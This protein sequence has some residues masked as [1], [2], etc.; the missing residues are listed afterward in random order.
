MTYEE[1]LDYLNHYG[2]SQWKLG[3]ERTLGLLEKLGNP[4]KKLKFIHV[5]GSNGKGST[6][7][8]LERIFRE[9]GYKTGFFPSPYI[10]D[11]RERIQVSGDYISKESLARLTERVAD[12]CDT[13]AEHPT[14]FEMITAL[15]FLYF[16]EQNCDLVILEVGLGGSFDS[17]NVIDPPECAVITH[18][19]L[20]HTEY[21]GDTLA[22]IAEA[23]AGIIKTGS[24]VVTYENAREAM[25]VIKQVCAEKSCP[26]Y[27][28]DR[29]RV[30][31]VSTSFDGQKLVA[32]HPRQYFGN[33][34]SCR[35][36]AFLQNEFLLSEGLSLTLSLIG[37]YQLDNVAVVLTVVEV[38]RSRGYSVPEDAVCAGLKKVNWPARF[39]VLSREP[40]LIL[41]GGHNPQCAEALAETIRKYLPDEKVTF[42][43][44]VLADKDVDKILDEVL[45]LA[46]YFICLTPDSPRALAADEL[47]HIIQNKYSSS[48][49]PLSAHPDETSY[50]ITQTDNTAPQK[51]KSENNNCNTKA[52]SSFATAVSSVEEALRTAFKQN[53]PVIAFG[54]LYLAGQIR[55]R[56]KQPC[57]QFERSL[58]LS[59]RK[60]LSPAERA[61]KSK[62][63]CERIK[64]LPILEKAVTVLSYK[65]DGSEVDLTLINQY[66]EEKDIRVAYPVSGADGIM[67]AY[68]PQEGSCFEK[69]AFG[70]L[71]P[72]PSQSTLIHPEEI[73]LILIPCVAFDDEGNRMGHGKGYYDRYL[74]RCNKHVSAVQVA[75]EAQRI[76]RLVL[77]ETDEKPGHIVTE[78]RIL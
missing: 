77:I 25:E 1:A 52:D 69:G 44:G 32:R 54:S 66:M 61:T 40:L 19:G 35:T 14:H 11:F 33:A 21:L 49:I 29:K 5:A 4:Q 36:Y 47:A 76:E 45:P 37:D 43:M 50:S 31:L 59:R 2:W 30:E 60:A 26:L 28:A 38:M 71:A 55:S 16:A 48:A 18:L 75:F 72:I 74:P 39:E 78:S 13:M 63:I 22:K 10:E 67:E 64:K 70:I 7:A 9:A 15:G 68:L 12:V 51:N 34:S 3:L 56:Y 62:Q 73:D 24:A 8:M 42:I 27:L 57:R 58:A 23:K 46:S 17:T 65:A 41:D 20:E 6:C 53:K